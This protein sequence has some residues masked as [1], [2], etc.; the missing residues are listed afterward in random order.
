[1]YTQR[2]LGLAVLFLAM[3]QNAPAATTRYE[4]AYATFFGGSAWDQA[5]EAIVY[6]DGSVLVGGM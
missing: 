2:R 5:R 4:I 1:M 3:L 6:P